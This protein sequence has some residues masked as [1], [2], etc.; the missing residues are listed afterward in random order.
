VARALKGPREFWSAGVFRV[1]AV[2]VLQ[3]RKV[4]KTPG[5]RRKKLETVRIAAG[6]G[7]W[8]W[9]VSHAKGLRPIGSMKRKRRLGFA[10]ALLLV[11]GFLLRVDSGECETSRIVGGT[12]VLSKD[13]FPWMVSLQKRVVPG[14]QFEHFCGGSLIDKKWVLT[15]AH[16]V[17]NRTPDRVL[18]GLTDLTED[19]SSSAKT[20]RIE[21]V[22]VN[23]DYYRLDDIALL[24]LKDELDGIELMYLNLDDASIETEGTILRVIGWGHTEEDSE[25]ISDELQQVDVPVYDEEA[26]KTSYAGLNDDQICA[27]YVAGG[28]DSCAGDSGGPLFHIDSSN[29]VAQVGIVSFGTGCARSEFPGVYTRV[30]NYINWIESTSGLNLINRESATKFPT[31]YPTRAPTQFP[32]KYPTKAPTA[33]PTERS[34]DPLNRAECYIFEENPGWV[35]DETSCQIPFYYVN[36]DET[37]YYEYAPTIGEARPHGVNKLSGVS[38]GDSV[39]RWCPA[40]GETVY[41][42]KGDNQ[43]QWGVV[44]CEEPDR[45]PTPAPTFSPT[46]QSPTRSPTTGK[47]T[48]FPTKSPSKSP[49]PFPSH[50]PTR[51]PTRFPTESPTRSPTNVPTKFPTRKPTTFPSRSP[52]RKPTASPTKTPSESPTTAQPTQFPT[53]SPTSEAFAVRD[54][55]CKTHATVDACS[56]DNWHNL[57]CTIRNDE[58]RGRFDVKTATPSATPTRTPSGVDTGV[59]GAN[60]KGATTLK[61]N[62]TVISIAGAFGVIIVLVLIAAILIV[63]RKKKQNER[64]EAHNAMAMSSYLGGA[65]AGGAFPYDEESSAAKSPTNGSRPFFAR[66]SKRPDD[67]DISVVASPRFVASNTPHPTFRSYESFEGDVVPPPPPPPP[68]DE[69]NS[70]LPNTP[71]QLP[72]R[73]RARNP[74]PG[75]GFMSR[76]STRFSQWTNV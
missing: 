20:A 62:G 2:P 38:N 56:E 24:E 36:G 69:V 46:T 41:E 16:C 59:N 49:T 12:K 76:V 55:F 68:I 42:V 5:K 43:M 18:I 23:E 45:L 9:P 67:Q 35:T 75:L 48:S 14:N 39:M 32:T 21:R 26:C 4:A 53:R 63:R 33:R 73:A 13:E 7:V 54:A 64:E 66:R 8:S 6:H 37:S 60:S 19:E 10:E 28:R 11:V 51:K 40:K 47:P 57:Q 52:T 74:P 29:R 65:G 1:E 17:E 44:I 31:W 34:F 15:A 27:G 50:E 22:F 61:E 72:P 58:C 25:T 30:R 3:D 71:P 70:Q